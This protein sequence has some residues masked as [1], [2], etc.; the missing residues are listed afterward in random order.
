MFESL[1]NRSFRVIAR[2]YFVLNGFDGILTVLGITAGSFSAG[3]SN[4][5]ILITS[6]LGAAIALGISGISGAYITEKAERLR[7][8]KELKEAMICDMENSIHKE[9]VERHSIMISLINGF[10]PFIC[11]FISIIPYFLV[12]YGIIAMN[13]GYYLSMSA[14]ILLM[15]ALGGFLGKIS[16]ESIIIYALKMIGVGILTAGLS[17]TLGIGA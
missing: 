15:A 14:S 9:N 4:P 10:S 13:S 12:L 17:L 16:K 2:R 6:G 7:K 8:F 11:A 1:K 3:V 5:L